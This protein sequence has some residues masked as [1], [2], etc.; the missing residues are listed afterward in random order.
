MMPNEPQMPTE[1]QLRHWVTE[2]ERILHELDE[3]NLQMPAIH[4]NQAIESLRT[5]HAERSQDI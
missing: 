1:A 3:G 2:L 5:F 4:V